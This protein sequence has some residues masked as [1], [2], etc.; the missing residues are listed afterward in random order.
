MIANLLQ[1]SRYEYRLV[2]YYGGGT[3]YHPIPNVI[4]H[5]RDGVNVTGEICYSTLALQLMLR[6]NPKQPTSLWQR[7]TATSRGR[8][9]VCVCVVDP[10][11]VPVCFSPCCCACYQLLLKRKS[12]LWEI[13]SGTRCQKRAEIQGAT[14]T[15]CIP[16]PQSKHRN[17]KEINQS[18]L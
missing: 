12:T 11:F 2:P 6:R 14:D 5:Y 16:S 7:H 8:W 4:W 1:V 10:V 9:C 18:T 3:P 15:A 13:E 17:K